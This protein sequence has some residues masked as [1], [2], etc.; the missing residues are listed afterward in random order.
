MGLRHRW[1][2]E[3]H[4]ISLTQHF[5]KRRR[6][7]T[8]IADRLIGQDRIISQDAHPERTRPNCDLTPD[9]PEA[10]DTDGLVKQFDPDQPV[11]LARAGSLNVFGDIP[12][13]R[14]DHRQGRI[15]YRMFIRTRGRGDP[16]TVFGRA[17]DVDGVI[18]NPPPRNDLQ[19]RRSRKNRLGELIST[20][21]HCIHTLEERNE[22]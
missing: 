9:A 18:A 15:G 14:K 22:F 13:D 5:L 8:T 20:R 16:D 11:P 12:R 4:P 19:A 1:G 3:R 17:V 2:V 10:N 21:E 7:R 6:F